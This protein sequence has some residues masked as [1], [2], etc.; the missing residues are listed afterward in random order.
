MT[1]VGPRDPTDQM[2]LPAT[3]EVA[4][5]QLP[6]VKPEQVVG[7]VLRPGRPI[8]VGRRRSDRWLA[9]SIIT[10]LVVSLLYVLYSGY[11]MTQLSTRACLP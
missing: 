7:G 1:T 8:T 9:R 6:G 5:V 4:I 3:E 10:L 11:L 2:P